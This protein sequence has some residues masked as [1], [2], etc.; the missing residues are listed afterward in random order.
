MNLLNAIKKMKTY[1]IV[2]TIGYAIYLFAALKGYRILGDDLIDHQKMGNTS[3]HT[4][5]F[6]HK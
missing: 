5:Q 2:C 4:H 3:S 1:F 6:Y